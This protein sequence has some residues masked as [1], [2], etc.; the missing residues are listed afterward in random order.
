MVSLENFRRI[1][2]TIAVVIPAHQAEHQ[3]DECLAA[4]LANGFEPSDILVVDDGSRDATGERARTHGVKVI[5]NETPLQPAEAR[6]RGVAEVDAEIVLFVDADVVIRPGV[7]QRVLKHFEDE[8]IT[9][10]IGSYDTEPPA[11]AAVSR[12]RNLLHHHVHQKSAGEAETFWTGLGAVRR[13]AFMRAGGLRREWQNIEDV[14]FGVRLKRMGGRIVLDPA[15]Q[16]THLKAWTLGSMFR[17]DLYGRAVPWTRLLMFEGMEGGGLNTASNHRIAALSVAAFLGFMFLALFDASFLW[18]ALVAL[19]VFLA[20][21]AS[22]WKLLARVGGPGLALKAIPFHALHYVA[23]L[24][25]YARVVL[26][27]VPRRRLRGSES[28]ASSTG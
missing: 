11:P 20:V 19:V 26:F 13:E 5:R 8:S 25:G 15:I 23:A 16:G 22:L 18:L 3:I 14:E 28:A 24:L 21:N 9:A 27:E 6:N 7:R 1:E 12:Y 10:V 17:T 4:V 2:P